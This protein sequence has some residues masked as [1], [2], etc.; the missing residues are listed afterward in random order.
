MRPIMLAAGL[1]SRRDGFA[2]A[3]GARRRSPLE[4]GLIVRAYVMVWV[5]QDLCPPRYR[6]P[7]WVASGGM[8]DLYRA[9]D[10]VLER[11]VAIKLL[12]ER[13]AADEAVRSRFRREALAAA[14][15]SDAPNTV[16]IFDVGEWRGTPFIVM[17]YVGGGTLEQV[18]RGGAQR[19][20]RALPWLAQAAHSLDAAH[21]RGIVH[22]DVKPANLLLDEHGQ[23]RVGDFGIATAAGLDSLTLTGTML[24]TAGYLA[25]EQAQGRPVSGATDEYALAVVGYE[26]L[27]GTRP[28]AR[29]SP[30]AEAAAHIYEPVPSAARTNRALPGAVDAVFERALA[31]DPAARFPSCVA[32][33]SALQSRFEREAATATL[34]T[35]TTARGEEPTRVIPGSRRRS[36][37][38]AIWAGLLLLLLVGAGLCGALLAGAGSPARMVA[39]SASTRTVTTTT[40][41]TGRGS[42]LPAATTSPPSLA[43]PAAAYEMNTRGYRLM[44]AGNYAAALTLLRQS[45][46]GLVDPANPVTAYANFNLGQT[47]VQLGQ[48][49]AAI[50]YLQR[51]Q[52]LEPARHEVSDAIDYATRCAGT[53]ARPTTPGG[54]SAH[55]HGHGANGDGNQ[56]D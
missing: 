25:P 45:V 19:P 51:A 29:D 14:R 43:G 12:G 18:L 20:D 5:E 47:L 39:A 46:A 31:K 22:R 28:Y 42:T 7:T 53:E 34:M 27:T 17:E 48:C 15:L 56:N 1:A 24:G 49:A 6:D 2:Y 10:E 50:P 11:P 13:F 4:S 35:G 23:I 32:F 21:A 55:D 54:P 41:I 3:W 52:Q 44:L 30:T 33:A 16:T 8:G 40:T 9:V 37:P 36:L 26:L 38:A